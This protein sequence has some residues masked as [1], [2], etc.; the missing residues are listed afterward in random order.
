MIKN[1]TKGGKI[2]KKRSVFYLVAILALLVV[3]AVVFFFNNRVAVP[4]HV[5][6]KIDLGKV[7]GSHLNSKIDL[8][9]EIVRFPG[10]PVNWSGGSLPHPEGGGGG[11]SP[12]PNPGYYH[13]ES[14]DNDDNG[15]HSH[16]SDLPEPDGTPVWGHPHVVWTGDG[17]LRPADGYC[18]KDLNVNQ[19]VVPL[20]LGTPFSGHPNVVWDGNGLLRPAYG[21]RWENWKDPI[22]S[23]FLVVPLT[24]KEKIQEILPG[25]LRS[26]KDKK[27]RDWIVNN[28]DCRF[29]DRIQDYDPMSTLPQMISPWVG[30]GPYLIFTQS[31]LTETKATRENLIA[32]ES[33]KLFFTIM[34]D[35]P[36][37][38]GKTLESWFRDFERLHSS[39]IEIMENAK[40]KDQNED[41]PKIGDIELVSMFGYIF[42]AHALQLDKP[43]DK[44]ARREWDEAI[45][46]FKKHVNPLL[47][48]R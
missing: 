11:S 28:V 3:S 33:G 26:S 46:E 39:I 38:D 10:R 36:V 42:R 45:H 1:Q 20:P 7:G 41:F 2:M 40:S 8:D 17:H 25:A 35:K 24:T 18:W 15:G 21:Y 23:N 44:K 14:G 22:G 37:K 47:R 48:S 9:E 12:E 43:K 34:K 13:G 32:F 30:S 5:S 6:S 29:S 16:N 27:I 31:F 4:D 19:Q